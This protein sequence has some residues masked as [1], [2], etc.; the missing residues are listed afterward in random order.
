[1]GLS[2][3]RSIIDAHGG[4]AVFTVPNAETELRDSARG[5]VEELHADSV[6]N[7]SHRP[8]FED[9]KR[10]SSRGAGPVNV[11]GVG[12]NKNGGNGIPGGACRAR[13]RSRQEYGYRPSGKPFPGDG[14]S[15]EIGCDRKVS[16]G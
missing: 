13:V 11:I 3:C 15:E 10:R 1:M 7:A 16:T 12:S 9:S 14:G 6:S 2:I 8:A 4:G 5:L